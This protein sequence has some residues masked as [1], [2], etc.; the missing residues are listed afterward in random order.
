MIDRRERE[1]LVESEYYDRQERERSSD[2]ER[3]L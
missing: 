3:V 1:A 2:R